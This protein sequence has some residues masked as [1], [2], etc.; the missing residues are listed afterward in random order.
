MN[1]IAAALNPF[2]VK[3]YILKVLVVLMGLAIIAFGVSVFLLVGL[4]TDPVTVFCDGLGR[5]ARIQPGTALIIL[6]TVVV[7]LL[8]LFKRKYL[9]IATFLSWFVNG[10][11]M[12]F[13]TW[14]LGGVIT[15]ALPFALRVLLMLAACVVLSFGVSLYLN[16]HLGS[17]PTDTIGIWISEATNVQFRWIRMAVDAFFVLMGSLLGGVVGLGTLSGMFLTGPVVQF[18]NPMTMR[19]VQRLFPEMRPVTDTVPALSVDDVARQAS[20]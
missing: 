17:G 8:A 15:P 11:I 2:A 9:N 14:A 12:N 20:K 6:N 5:V 10:F 4:G 19:F 1:R 16:V 13:F 18:F 7:V 3:R